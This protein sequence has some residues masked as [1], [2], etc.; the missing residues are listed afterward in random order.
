MYIFNRLIY[1]HCRYPATQYY[2]HKKQSLDLTCPALSVMLVLMFLVYLFG[3]FFPDPFYIW[4]DLINN[5]LQLCQTPTLFTARWLFDIRVNIF[6][7]LTGVSSWSVET[8]FKFEIQCEVIRWVQ[9]GDLWWYYFLY[10][11]VVNVRNNFIVGVS[12]IW[13]SL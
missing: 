1:T 10:W 3:N 12:R 2:T 9:T 13:N 7:I 11:V 4:R 5:W 6:E 8:E